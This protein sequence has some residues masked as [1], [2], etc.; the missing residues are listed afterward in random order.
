MDRILSNDFLRGMG[1][2]VLL[3]AIAVAAMGWMHVRQKSQNRAK[4]S[5]SAANHTG[6]YCNVNTLDPKD[7]SAHRIETTKLIFKTTGIVETASGYEFRFD[8]ASVT[9]NEL[10]AW[11]EDESKCCPFFDFHI[12]LEREGKLVCL[13]LTGEEGIKDFIRAEFKLPPE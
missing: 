5:V 3:A 10:A 2:V 8:P 13:R 11:V 4:E 9:V 1:L 7:R 6:F 12:D